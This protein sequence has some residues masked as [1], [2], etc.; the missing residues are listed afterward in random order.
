MMTS[1]YSTRQQSNRQTKT[2]QLCTE[3]TINKE[4]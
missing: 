1:W 4:V 2:Q 3:E